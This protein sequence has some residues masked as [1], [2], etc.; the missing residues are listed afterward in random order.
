MLA[1]LIALPVLG[2]LLILQTAVISRIPLLQG[3]AD[4]VL[5]AL[6]AWALQKPV[7]TG[8]HWGIIGG[9]LV[10][11]VSGLPFGVTLVGYL[12]AVGLALLLRQRVWQVPLLAMVVTTFTGTLVVHMVALIALRVIGTPLPFWQSLNLVI[13]PSILL[14]LLL[15]IPV[16]AVIGDLAKWVYP[17]Q[18][19]M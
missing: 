11:Y 1:I 17:E 19:E 8:L 6:M 9:L 3:T 7:A 13:L 2:G 18:L 10:S 14:N 5:L 15:A 4:V 16:Y 12:L